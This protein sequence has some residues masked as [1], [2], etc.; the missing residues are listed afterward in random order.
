MSIPEFVRLIEDFGWTCEI[1]SL[2]IINAFINRRR[3]KSLTTFTEIQNSNLDTAA[4]ESWWFDTRNQIIYKHFESKS[5]TEVLWDI[6]SGPGI[7]SKYLQE[8]GKRCIAIEPNRQGVIFSAKRGVISIES[9]LQS[10]CLPSASIHQIGLFDVLE[11]V[12]DRQNLL[13]EIKRVLTSSGELLI[14]VPALN[15]LWSAADEHAGHFVRYSRKKLERELNA[16]GFK[17]KES[18]YF[19]STLVL[20]LLL[21]RAIPYRLGIKQPIDDY[22]LL[23]QNGGKLGKL[24]QVIEVRLNRSFLIGTSLFAVAEKDEAL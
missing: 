18:H 16:N 7:V 3:S 19:F 13:S 20:P 22:S 6:G 11:H 5:K 9:N 8:H 12:E 17:L 10:L 15:F 2:G 24:L 21:L 23:K 1:E 14:T 4:S